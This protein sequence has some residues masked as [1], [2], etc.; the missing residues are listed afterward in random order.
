MD[1]SHP[2]VEQTAQSAPCAPPTYH[3]P[4][5]IEALQSEDTLIIRVQQL[6]YDGRQSKYRLRTRTRALEF[7]RVS[8]IC[9][10]VFHQGPGQKNA[11]TQKNA[12]LV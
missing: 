8:P 1:R 9:G 12:T 2:P 11:K 3:P 6:W 10:C 4:K 7:Q 5:Y